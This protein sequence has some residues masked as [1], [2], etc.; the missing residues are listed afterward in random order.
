VQALLDVVEA[1]PRRRAFGH[2]GGERAAHGIGQRF[3]DLPA[4]ARRTRPPGRRGEADQQRA[5]RPGHA[6]VTG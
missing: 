5:A 6:A 3:L 1:R 2:R 4:G